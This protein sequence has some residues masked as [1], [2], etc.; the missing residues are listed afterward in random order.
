MKKLTLIIFLAVLCSCGSINKYPL[1][2]KHRV[3]QSIES[4]NKR[5]YGT[6]NPWADKSF[7][8]FSKLFS[9]SK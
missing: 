4:T 1:N 2:T 5:K 7:Y 3:K 8:N 6:A 9:N